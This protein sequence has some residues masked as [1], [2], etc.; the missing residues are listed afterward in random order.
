MFQS[1]VAPAPLAVHEVSVVALEPERAVLT[2]AGAPIA[3]IS[4]ASARKGTRSASALSPP[5]AC[6]PENSFCHSI[7][8]TSWAV[9][10]DSP[11]SGSAPTP[12]SGAAAGPPHVR[13]VACSGTGRRL[14][15]D[16]VIDLRRSP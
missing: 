13:E 9:R 8:P 12:P 16:A 11:S 2:A 6:R 10:G 4:A 3:R 7:P 1:K 5:S 15:A 14:A